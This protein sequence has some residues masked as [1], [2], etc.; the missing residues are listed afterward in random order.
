MTSPPAT[1]K[2]E[3]RLPRIVW[4]VAALALL[5]LFN[6]FFTPGFYDVDVR[7]GRLHGSLIDILDR[8]APLMLV[9]LGM[10]LVIATAGIDLSVGAVMAIAGAVAACLVTRPGYS[11]LA[12]IDL[13]SS[14]TL[15]VIAAA[16]AAALAGA[17]NGTLVG[18]FGI[19]PIVAT[20]VLMVAGRG[21]AQLL[22]DG[23]IVTFTDQAFVR[24]GSGS[25]LGMPVSVWI[26]LAAATAIALLARATALG[27]FLE[28]IGG[29]RV[30]SH[31][32]GVPAVRLIILVYGLCGTLSGLAGL[33]VAADIQASD[34]NN[35]GL[36]IELDAI[37]AVVIGGT[38]LTGGRFSLL[39][40][41]VGALLIQSLTTTILSR[42]VPVEW[43]LVVKAGVVI[44]VC[45]LQ[46]PRFR[47]VFR[48]VPDRGAA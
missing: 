28:A 47:A 25:L 1:T 42:G 10:T 26:V 22:T 45:L 13:G 27:L 11:P 32:S 21:I 30:A 18:I 43:T 41:I 2:G 48:R 46:A 34:V 39:G 17:C 40:S 24:L 20:L 29:N 23:Q 14:F 19:Q 37:L 4:P 5:L 38:A 9:S 15:I 3:K 7:D 6:V 16:L 35:T 8:A 33:L 12:A 44:S 36:Y 31:Q